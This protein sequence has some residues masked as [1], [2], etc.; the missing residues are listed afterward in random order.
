L[1]YFLQHFGVTSVYVLHVGEKPSFTPT[2]DKSIFSYIITFVFG[3]VRILNLI[4]AF[5]DI[6][7]LL[8]LS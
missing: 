6:N 8:I 2:T 3:R 4:V 5:P 7:L 1:E